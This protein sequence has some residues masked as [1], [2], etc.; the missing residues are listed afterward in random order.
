MI[1][2]LHHSE[3]QCFPKVL[4]IF[5]ANIANGAK[6]VIWDNLTTPARSGALLIQS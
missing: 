6:A 3:R 5:E 1:R 2:V 4:G